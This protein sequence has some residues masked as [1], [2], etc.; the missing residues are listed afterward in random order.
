MAISIA[1]AIAAA[2]AAAGGLNAMGAD[3][4]Y[5]AAAR[6]EKYKRD[7]ANIDRGIVTTWGQQTG[8]MF[9]EYDQKIRDTL[10]SG[11]ADASGILGD[12]Y[13]RANRLGGMFDEGF[14]FDYEQSPG[15]AHLLQQGEQAVNRAGAAR[16]DWGGTGTGK[17]LMRFNIGLAAQDYGNQYGR[18]MGEYRQ[19]LGLAGNLDMRDMSLGQLLAQMRLGTA[20]GIAGQHSQTAQNLGTNS[21]N[22]SN[23]FA[24]L[25]AGSVA[26]AGSA[27]FA[28][29]GPRAW[30]A[31]ANTG[32]ANLIDAGTGAASAAAGAGDAPKK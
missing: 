29:G 7:L 25:G 26:G 19:Q 5:E 21:Q 14:N 32:M 4:Q 17:N 15:Y 20:S 9:T 27:Q 6:A 1:A 3:Q 12:Y 28:G 18:A 24:T 11:E 13:G 10:M 2:A 22:L 31:A 30:G 16:G 23:L 8:D